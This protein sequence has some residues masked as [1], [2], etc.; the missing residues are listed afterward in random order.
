MLTVR[1]SAALQLTA[2]LHASQHRKGTDTPYLAHLLA[3]AAIVLEYGGD[4]DTAIAALLHDSIEDRS[5]LFSG[6]SDDLRSYL[7]ARFGPKVLS[8]VEE[9]TDADTIPKPPWQARKEAYIASIAH[10]SPEGLLV[11][12]ADK[13]HNTR[14]LVRDYKL[15]GDASWERFTGGKEGS[16]WYYQSLVAAFE[17]NPAS[18][19]GLVRELKTTVE[20]LLELTT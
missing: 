15:F 9:C 17:Q 12:C 14:S 1:F 3:V 7:E 6:G 5:Y 4:E 19:Q 10:K 13:L 20:Q 11:S 2:E 8:I 16:L 18:P